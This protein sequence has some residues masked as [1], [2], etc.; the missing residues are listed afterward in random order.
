MPPPAQHT[1]YLPD[2]TATEA[3]ARRLAPLVYDRPD[4]SAA[5]GPGAGGRIHLRGD[6]GAGKTSFARALLRACGISG[7]IKSP[8]Y[9]LLESY[10]VFNLYLYHL[11][12]YRFS[13]SREWL[14]A[15]FRE[16]LREDALVLIEWPERAGDLLSPPDLEISLEYLDDGRRADLSAHTE[17]GL[18]WLNAILSP[19][20]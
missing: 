16:I 2:E 4:A 3:L 11:D 12:F 9:A 17:R 10:K 13:E 20:P 19:G 7:R 8:S 18:K 1:L 5:P 6:L 15:G 14:D